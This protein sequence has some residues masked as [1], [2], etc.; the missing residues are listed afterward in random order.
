MHSE[1]EP[2]AEPKLELELEPWTLQA[3][4]HRSHLFPFLV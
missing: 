2:E 1:P 4:T 3:A